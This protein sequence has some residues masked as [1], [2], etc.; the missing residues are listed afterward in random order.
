MSR[1]HLEHTVFN[2]YLE[3]RVVPLIMRK[4]YGEFQDGFSSAF[5]VPLYFLDGASLQSP[6]SL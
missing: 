2:S 3:K 6:F 4:E 1:E 5:I